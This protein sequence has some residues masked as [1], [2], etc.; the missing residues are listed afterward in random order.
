MTTL[1]PHWNPATE[2]TG[3]EEADAPERA[4]LRE[5]KRWTAGSR[6]WLAVLVDVWSGSLCDGHAQCDP[7][8]TNL[9]VFESRGG[10]L[11]LVGQ[12]PAVAHHGGGADAVMDT[13][14]RRLNRETPLL[15]VRE[16]T[17]PP[18]R[19]LSTLRLFVVEGSA[20]RPVFERSVGDTTR[21]A[22]GKKPAGCS[23]TVESDEFGTPPYPLKISEHCTQTGKS[24]TEL[25]RWNGTRYALHGPASD[26]AV[27]DDDFTKLTDEP[28]E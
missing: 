1:F 2:K 18:D 17:H 12:T 22:K 16:T 3:S 8:P 27:A 24:S 15:A 14:L 19:V 9:A 4:R 10:A 13:Q 25:W 26:A 21:P 23:A 7:Q 28:A 6:T 20:V 5:A 11:V